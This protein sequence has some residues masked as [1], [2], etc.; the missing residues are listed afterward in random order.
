MLEPQGFDSRGAEPR[1]LA[2]G[3][4]RWLWRLQSEALTA[5]TVQMTP[6]SNIAL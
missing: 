4:R 2:D 5:L 3:L 6:R 1:G